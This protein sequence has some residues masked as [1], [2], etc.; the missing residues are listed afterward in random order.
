[1][2]TGYGLEGELP[3]SWLKNMQVSQMV[4]KFKNVCTPPRRL[5]TAQQIVFVNKNE[6]DSDPNMVTNA[7]VIFCIHF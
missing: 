6:R 2:E 7:C 1:M 5:C 3:D 4:P